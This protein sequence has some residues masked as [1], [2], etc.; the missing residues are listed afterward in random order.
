[1]LLIIKIS[2]MF[3]VLGFIMIGMAG[4]VFCIHLTQKLN[5]TVRD[6]L[7]ISTSLITLVTVLM[8]MSYKGLP[9]IAIYGIGFIF[10]GLCSIPIRIFMED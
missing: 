10:I 2:L 4:F 6:I 8:N 7:Y 1:M 9:F 5:S 3:F